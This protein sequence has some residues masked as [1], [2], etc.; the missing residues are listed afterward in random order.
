MLE[1]EDHQS[2]EEVRRDFPSIDA[3]SC[4]ILASTSASLE[5]MCGE[6][7][8]VAVLGGVAGTS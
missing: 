2:S 6:G 5:E 1:D 8:D 3:P 7:G 4:L